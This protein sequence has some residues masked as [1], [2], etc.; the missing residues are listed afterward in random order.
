MA[1]EQRS[2]LQTSRGNTTIAESVVSKVVG[3][4]IQEVEGVSLGVGASR[5]IGGFMETVTGANSGGPTRG[6]SVEVG[7][8][9]TA[10]DLTMGAW[11]RNLVTVQARPKRFPQL[12]QA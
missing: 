8:T 7:E 10:I 1:Q 3:M 12:S 5:A 2:P 4:A 11:F 9:E 6:V